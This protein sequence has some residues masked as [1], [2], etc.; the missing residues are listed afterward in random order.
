MS[1]GDLRIGGFHGNVKVVGEPLQ[2][3]QIFV[4]YLDYDNCNAV[5]GDKNGCDF[6]WS[7]ARGRARGRGWLG[8]GA[9]VRRRDA[10][11]ACPGDAAHGLHGDPHRWGGV[12]HRAGTGTGWACVCL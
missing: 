3:G 12:G 4:C 2:G 7:L 8:V 6:C 11:G 9:L 5:V 1:G 10:G